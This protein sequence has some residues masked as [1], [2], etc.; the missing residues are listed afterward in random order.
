MRA[1]TAILR[2]HDVDF[3][4]VF[5]SFFPMKI[6]HIFIQELKTSYK[7]KK[8]FVK[9]IY[10]D[11]YA[12]LVYWCYRK[13]YKFMSKYKITKC[14]TSKK[15]VGTEFEAVIIKNMTLLNLVKKIASDVNG[16]K[17]DI[18]EMKTDIADLK[19][20]MTKV[21]KRLDEHSEFITKQTDF[22]KVVNDYMKSHLNHKSI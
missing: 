13:D 4:I 15:L 18:V 17:I 8:L 1:Y 2:T 5:L 11:A 9:S 10:V 22:N 14:P 16:I 20:R 21:E 19:V 6:N 3:L 7:N 12:M